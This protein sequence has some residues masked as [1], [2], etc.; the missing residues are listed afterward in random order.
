MYVVNE[1]KGDWVYLSAEEKNEQNNTSRFRSM[2]FKT[3]HHVTFTNNIWRCVERRNE[4]R[5][6]ANNWAVHSALHTQT[7]THTGERK[8]K[9]HYIIHDNPVKLTCAVAMGQ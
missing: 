9:L 5:K 2:Q 1:E 4:Q 6:K 3:V 7:H 8:Q